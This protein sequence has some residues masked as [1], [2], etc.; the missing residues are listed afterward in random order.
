MRKITSKKFEYLGSLITDYGRME[1]EIIRRKAQ[2][3]NAFSK[4]LSLLSSRNIT[5]DIKK[6]FFIWNVGLMDSAEERQM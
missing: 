3:K 5:L 2:A 1:P 4:K 6:H